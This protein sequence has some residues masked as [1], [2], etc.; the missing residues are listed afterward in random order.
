[1]VQQ[2]LCIERCQPSFS[3]KPVRYDVVEVVVVG[4]FV[5]GFLAVG[6]LNG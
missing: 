1:M 6:I 2:V 5:V 4:F 3:Q